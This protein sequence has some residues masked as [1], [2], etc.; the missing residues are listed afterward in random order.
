MEHKK[1]LMSTLMLCAAAVSATAPAQEPPEQQRYL[2]VVAEPADG[3]FFDPDK[4]GTGVTLTKVTDKYFYGLYYG[5]DADG[6][7]MWRN[8]VGEFVQEKPI[9]GQW[10]KMG[11]LKA[12]TNIA[13]NGQVL[14]G[15]YKEQSEN[16]APEGEIEITFHS[17][18]KATISYGGTTFNGI[19]PQTSHAAVVGGRPFGFL[20]SEGDHVEVR[21]K[22]Q[23]QAQRFN[24]VIVTAP[25]R[26]HDD[27]RYEHHV[28]IGKSHPMFR[29]LCSTIPAAWT[30]DLIGH[31][32]YNPRTGEGM[33]A[34]AEFD[35]PTQTYVPRKNIA[36]LIAA[37]DGVVFNGK[38]CEG[39]D[40]QG[41]ILPN[42]S[43]MVYFDISGD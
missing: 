21:L 29:A 12:A 36:K 4:P 15:P 27:G 34:I 9:N 40:I 42:R 18:R 6:R 5:Y 22:V 1:L 25:V 41:V 2:D 3:G 19:F 38:T 14:G 31:I 20:D 35:P 13:T 10:A 39:R 23:D 11:S 32:S 17:A 8:F 33:L 26:E 30:S 37:R 28:A 43:Q 16:P 24:D 7:P